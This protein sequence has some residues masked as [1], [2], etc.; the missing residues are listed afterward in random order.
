M[1]PFLKKVLY[2]FGFVLLSTLVLQT[3]L[4]IRIYNKT[5]RGHD[6]L[7][8][9]TNVN[10]DVVFLGSSRCWAHFD[11]AFFDTAFKLKSVNIGVD[12]HS[13]ISMA[14]LRLK[15]Y[16]SGNKPPGFAILSFDPLVYAGSTT[17]NLNFVHKDDFARYAFLPAQK[18]L[19]V[20]NYFKF[21]LPEKY[22]PLYS[23]FK[24][25]LLKDCILL[26]NIDNYVQ[27]GYEK[28]DEFWDTTANPV[29]DI[30]K[31]NFLKKEDIPSLT[32]S[33]DDLHKLCL[34]N[35]IKLLCIQTPVYK[36]IY[37]KMVFLST[38]RICKELLIPFVDTNEDDIIDNLK[39]F[40]NSDHLNTNGVAKMNEI[41]KKDS[42]LSSFLNYN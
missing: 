39:Y 27:Y 15:Y 26:N 17:H 33:M 22:I 32:E 36:I 8:Q 21:S 1:G 28:H 11:P 40:Y 42:V 20:L 9:T 16:L 41:L 7:Y 35:N 23:I 37:E 13:E 34:K 38:Q 29:S 31:N 30:L 10:A 5:V 4:S 3:M 2:F 18:N 24:Y 6:N 12:G 19:P 14:I 25:R